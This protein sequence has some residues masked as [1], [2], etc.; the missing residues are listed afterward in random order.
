MLKVEYVQD[1]GQKAKTRA[2]V[3]TSL[4]AQEENMQF[5]RDGP[6]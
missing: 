5:F 6:V 4:K 1:K 3:T 2:Y